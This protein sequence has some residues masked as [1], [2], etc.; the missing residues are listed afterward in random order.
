MFFLACPLFVGKLSTRQA[1]PAM[2]GEITLK[3]EYHDEQ[4]T[5]DSRIF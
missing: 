2:Q 5:K 4:K 1:R 3:I